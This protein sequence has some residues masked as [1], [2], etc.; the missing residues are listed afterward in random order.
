MSQPHRLSIRNARDLQDAIKSHTDARDRLYISSRARALG[1]TDLLP[2][3]WN[4]MTTTYVNSLDRQIEYLAEEH[5]LS[6]VQLKTV[7]LRGVED[8]VSGDVTYGSATMYG[9][10][11][12]QRFINERGTIIDTDLVS[13]DPESLL[14][15]GIEISS[16]SFFSPE[17]LYTS[18]EKM[19]DLFKPGVVTCITV[20]DDAW[21]T[22]DGELGNIQWQYQLN[23]S[24]GAHSFEIQ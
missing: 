14:D 1:R 2:T 3:A 6:S 10:A 23:T 13:S 8:F 4:Q 16:E 21:L 20:E 12:V 11:R 17:V 24:T 19:A 15:C 7:Y 22:I 9:L 5:K 18:G